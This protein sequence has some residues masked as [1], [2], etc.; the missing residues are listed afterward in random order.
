MEFKV[1]DKVMLNTWTITP[2]Y[3]EVIEVGNTF[4]MIKRGQTVSRVG[5]RDYHKRF[6]RKEK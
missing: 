6:V 3:A 2:I 4:V 1:G 5:S